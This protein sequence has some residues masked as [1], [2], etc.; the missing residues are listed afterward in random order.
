MIILCISVNDDLFFDEKSN[1]SLIISPLINL[2]SPFFKFDISFLAKT[3]ILFSLDDIMS[4]SRVLIIHLESIKGSGLNYHLL[5]LLVV[6]LQLQMM[7]I[8]IYDLRE[9]FEPPAL[10]SLIFDKAITVMGN[11][12]VLAG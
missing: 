12:I 9:I 10:S 5:R 2:F 3:V 8:Y 11:L 7:D 4:L 6:I 1:G